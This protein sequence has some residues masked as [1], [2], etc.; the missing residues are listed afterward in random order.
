MERLRAISA[1]EYKFYPAEWDCIS[2]EAK[3]FIRSLLL[4]DPAQRL[5]ARQ[6]LTHRWMMFESKSTMN[7]NRAV[8]EL[9]RFNARKVAHAVGRRGVWD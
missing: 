8:Q 1:G 3:D 4:V 6:A 9:E 7:M 2:A 5:T